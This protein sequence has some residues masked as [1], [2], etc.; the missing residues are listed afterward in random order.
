MKKIRIIAIL[1]ILAL[2]LSSFTVSAATEIENEDGSYVFDYWGD[3]QSTPIPYKT[4]STFEFGSITSDSL[5]LTDLATDSMGKY[6]IAD[7]KNNCVWVVTSDFKSFEKI[8]G[9]IQNGENIN[10][11]SCEGVWADNDKIYVANTAG[12]N[13]VVLDAKTLETIIVIGKPEESEWSSTVDFEPV[14]LSTDNGGRIYVI[15]RNQ[16]QGIVQFTKEGK[17]IGFLGA[18]EVNPTAWDIFIRTFGTKEMKNRVL[19]LVPT[20]FSNLICNNEGLVMTITETVTDDEIYSGEKIPVRLLN[21]LGKNILKNNGYFNTIGDVDFTLWSNENS[22]ASRFIDCAVSENG[23]YSLLDRKRAKVF[24]YDNDGNLLYVFGGKGSGVDCFEQPVSIVYNG[25]KIVVLDQSTSKLTCF[26][27]TT[28]TDLVLNAYNAHENGDFDEET[29]CW[30]E[31]DKEFSG[32]YLTNIGLGKMYY[33][34][35]N[36]R[37]AMEKFRLAENKTYYSKA[38][39]GWQ[40]QF[41]EK[42]LGWII[43]ISIAS[44]LLIVFVYKKL[45]CKVK[46]SE[47][48]LAITYKNGWNVIT[49]PFDGF[50]NLKWEGNGRVSS[51]TIIL[52]A[53]VFV[54]YLCSRFVPYISST[55]NLQQTNSIIDMV[56]LIALILLFVIANW[57]LT[58]LFDG[59]G[60]I[61]DIYIYTCHALMPYVLFSLPV[62]LIGNLLTNET[63]MLY[64]G[65]NILI[66]AYCIFLVISGTLTVHQFT[67]SKTILML[68]ICLAAVAI[69]VFLIVLCSSLVGN[70]A[71]FVLGLIREITLRYS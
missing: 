38:L 22:G 47:S 32:Y 39:K 56:A 66:L 60:A 35:G 46:Q 19:Q 43:L 44:I 69:M 53:A 50:W 20:E 26:E 18:L 6:F 13:V 62:L 48:L 17:F 57:C 2:F 21:P 54:N 1:C 55:E 24:T 8:T 30:K 34:E 9:Y 15:S 58:T 52:F 51:A 70:I 5:V 45:A 31:L 10:F 23:I 25:R 12:K 41:I 11:Q 63:I 16:T 67:L 27:P 28:F 59:K 71:D 49:H 29:T 37:A 61:K 36:Y 3:T 68:V 64:T 33:N 65:L 42:N 7:S 40:T 14:K 4:E